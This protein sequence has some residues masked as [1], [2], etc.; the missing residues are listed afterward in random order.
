MGEWTYSTYNVPPGRY[1][2]L[3]RYP[4]YFYPQ[5]VGDH[6]DPRYKEDV[7]T[8]QMFSKPL[9]VADEAYPVLVE[10]TEFVQ[11]PRSGQIRI[12]PVPNKVLNYQQW[13]LM[14]LGGYSIPPATIRHRNEMQRPSQPQEK[15]Y[16]KEYKQ[17]LP[18][19]VT[20][21]RPPYINQF[22]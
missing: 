20:I 8:Y 1:S 7:S 17:K 3:V 6:L 4:H 13:G 10:G 5:Q 14:D 16:N 9:V 21:P 19:P 12:Q 18:Y 11:T 2:R 22:F 15:P